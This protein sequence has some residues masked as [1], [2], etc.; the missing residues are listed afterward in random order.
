[1]DLEDFK[2]A[3]EKKGEDETFSC[4]ATGLKVAFNSKA[5]KDFN[6]FLCDLDKWYKHKTDYLKVCKEIDDHFGGHDKVPGDLG[7]YEM[8]YEH[9]VESL[10]TV[11]HNLFEKWT[12]KKAEN[13]NG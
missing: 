9:A 1:M 10:T 8:I 12:V 4:I 2:K 5:D 13:G 6:E 7:E 11:E 3:M